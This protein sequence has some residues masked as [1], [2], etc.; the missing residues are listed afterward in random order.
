M[1]ACPTVRTA[2]C[3]C[4]IGE[5]R[6]CDDPNSDNH[7]LPAL[8][9]RVR[10]HFAGKESDTGLKPNTA[11]FFGNPVA[12]EATKICAGNRGRDQSSSNAS[13]VP[14]AAGLAV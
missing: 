13:G 2:I 5:R 3:P 9:R 14:T 11:K 6:G 8:C 4:D 7:G 10:D 1:M 12:Q